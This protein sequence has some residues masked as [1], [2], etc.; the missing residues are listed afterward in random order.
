MR[1]QPIIYTANN[2]KQWD[3]DI[4]SENG[5]IPARPIGHNL[6]PI[7]YRFYV[8][9]LVLVGEYDALNWEEK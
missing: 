8:A 4:E 3:C 6:Y 2:I 9:W 1:R 5:W 7:L